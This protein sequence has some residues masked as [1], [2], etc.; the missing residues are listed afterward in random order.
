LKYQYENHFIFSARYSFAF[1]GQQLN[2]PISFNAFRFSVESSG[3][4]L[5]LVSLLLNASKNDKDRYQF[6]NLAYA[7]Y[8][9]IDAELK[10]YWYL[11]HNQI[12]VTR[13]MGGSGF[14]NYGNSGVLPYEKG[15]FAG[16]NN[17]I[18]AWPMN[19]LGPGSYHDS[20]T[21]K[22]ER[23]G[24]IVMVGNIEYRFP[25]F[26]AFK[27]ALFLD[28]GNI[29]Q[30]GD[31]KSFPKGEFFWKNVPND[32]A[33]GGGFGLRWDLNFFVI[34]LDAAAPLRDPAK[35]NGEKWVIKQT[36]PKSFV[37]NFGIGYPF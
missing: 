9:R 24:D 31:S 10:R 19:Q 6:F 25:I 34:R 3:N 37:L 22:I 7:Q 21:Y 33:V 35:P 1:S 30:H 12:L 14:T 16:G 26:G 18:R 28:A 5:N 20:T 15:F 4:S 36:R 13:L 27:G 17:N 11:T 32:L 2:R 23:I 8:I 29:W